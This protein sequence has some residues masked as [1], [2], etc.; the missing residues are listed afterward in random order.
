MAGCD[1]CKNRGSGK[2]LGVRPAG[3][4]AAEIPGRVSWLYSGVIL[5]A[6]GWL[7]VL[8]V[9]FLMESWESGRKLDVIVMAGFFIA[10]MLP[11]QPMLEIG[12]ASYRP[13]LI[14][15]LA[16]WLLARPGFLSEP[17]A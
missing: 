3:P 16:L 7:L 5:G 8:G 13:W 2:A 17:E 15:M 9:P 14:A 6:A 4:A 10:Q 11:L 1:W 12:F